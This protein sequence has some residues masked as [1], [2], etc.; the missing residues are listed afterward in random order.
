MNANLAAA[1]DFVMRGF[2]PIP[3]YRHKAP[4][5]QAGEIH[6]YRQQVAPAKL[7]RH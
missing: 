2:S 5:L 3:F 4:A 6:T 7:L 1:V